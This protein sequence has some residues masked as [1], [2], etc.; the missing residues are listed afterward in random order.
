MVQSNYLYDFLRRRLSLSPLKTEIPLNIHRFIFF[1]RQYH[2]YRY[3]CCV[4]TYLFKIGKVN[5]Q[6][7]K[8]K[9][10]GVFGAMIPFVMVIVAEPVPLLNS[11]VVG[12][13]EPTAVGLVVITTVYVPSKI[14]DMA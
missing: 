2:Y 11:Q 5:T 4:L 14:P 6:F 12:I 9:L 10:V 13:A 1:K 7:F 8:Q 3:F